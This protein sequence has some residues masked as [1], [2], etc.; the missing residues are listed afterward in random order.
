MHDTSTLFPLIRPDKL[1]V[2]MQ[3]LIAIIAIIAFGRLGLRPLFRG[4]ARTRSQEPFVA[5][6]FLVVIGA[7]LV[8]AT[9]RLSM[10]L[11]ALI[12]G[13]LLAGT[14]YRRQVEVTI[15][16]FKGLFVGV[17]LISVGM[18]LDIRTLGA[19]P[20]LVLGSSAA[21]IAGRH[22]AGPRLRGE[23]AECPAHGPAARPRRR[24]CLRHYRGG[25]R[26]AF[27]RAGSRKRGAVRH[28]PDDGDHSSAFQTG[29]P[30]WT[31]TRLLPR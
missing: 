7:A 31:T 19:H 5:A 12:G 30:A 26:R 17:F 18:T 14:E 4:V 27:A 3:A 9:A 8:T 23:L 2:P 20:L 25:A 10:A 6:C 13:L 22:A 29:R 28:R 15:E 1:T 24:I 16:P 21:E 11:G